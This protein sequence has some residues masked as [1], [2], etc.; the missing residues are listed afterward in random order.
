MAMGMQQESFLAYSLGTHV[1]YPSY[2]IGGGI[3]M[4][5]EAILSQPHDI[6]D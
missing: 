3:A 5:L 6:H 1:P 2:L 4:Y